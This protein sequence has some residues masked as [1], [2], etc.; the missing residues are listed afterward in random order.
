M[1]YKC[2]EC[3]RIFVEDTE[4]CPQCGIEIEEVDEDLEEIEKV[5]PN[6]DTLEQ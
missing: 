5:L 3:N 4:F 1:I 2:P 6:F